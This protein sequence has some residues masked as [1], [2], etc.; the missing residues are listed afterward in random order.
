[1]LALVGLLS[2]LAHTSWA[3]NTPCSGSKGGVARCQGSTFICNDGSVSASKKHCSGGGEARGI[4]GQG[5]SGMAPA[6]A[7][8][9]SCR[10]GQYCTGPRGGKYC[11][12]DNG[13]KSYLKK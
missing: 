12:A 10:G 1:M 6:R 9:C 3:A 11:L 7:G 13:R 5:G 4:I 2:F 8:D